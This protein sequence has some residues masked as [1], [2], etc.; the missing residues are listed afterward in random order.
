MIRKEWMT[1]VAQEE[2]APRIYALTLAGEMVE[3]M[4]MGQFVHLL[5][6]D[7]SMLLRRPISISQVDKSRHRCT[8]IYRVEGGGTARFSRMQVG[9]QMD[10]MGPL[11]TGFSLEGV[12]KE[13]S[14]LLIGGGIGVPPL[15]E[16]AKQAHAKGIKV[17]SVI[18]F[19]TKT[20]VI[21]E[22]ELAR[23]GEVLVTTD[24]GS[25][26]VRGY[27]SAVVDGLVEEFAAI[28]ACGAPAMMA[29][30]NEKFR[31]HPRAYLSLEARMACG[32]GACCAC[33]LPAQEGQAH[34]YKRVCKEGPVFTTGSV[35]LE[36]VGR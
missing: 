3:E 22:E 21:L 24:D 7:G 30:V 2:I 33:V 18:G 19:A 14:I 15:L 11:G 20:A 31:H 32:M 28:Y 23:Y 4:E 34:D 36:E 9:E 25:Y 29:Y 13:D 12:T 1:I 26:G 16:L 35:V 6:P 5:V 10:V 17:V 8:L 27:V